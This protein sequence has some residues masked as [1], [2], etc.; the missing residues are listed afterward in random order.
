MD[1]SPRSKLGVTDDFGFFDHHN[2]ASRS[3]SFDTYFESM[4]TPLKTDGKAFEMQSGFRCNLMNDFLAPMTS[5][6][7]GQYKFDLFDDS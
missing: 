2:M 7:G 4:E 6:A 3:T 5:I 1:F